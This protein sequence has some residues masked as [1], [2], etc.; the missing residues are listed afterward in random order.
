MSQELLE[1]AYHVKIEEN[2]KAAEERTS[3]KRAK[4][5]KKKE[6]KQKKQKKEDTSDTTNNQSSDTESEASNCGPEN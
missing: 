1:E 2:R 6:K 4:R 5:L 3:K